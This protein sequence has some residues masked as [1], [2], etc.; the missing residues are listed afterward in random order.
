MRCA[1]LGEIFREDIAQLSQMLGR[2]LSHWR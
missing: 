2:D 1:E